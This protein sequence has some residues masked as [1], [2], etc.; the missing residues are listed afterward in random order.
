[1]KKWNFVPIS[2]IIFLIVVNSVS[3]SEASISSI[4]TTGEIDLPKGIKA[5]VSCDVKRSL[6]Y[7]DELESNQ[8]S[9]WD[10]GIGCKTF[11]IEIYV[12]SPIDEWYSRELEITSFGSYD[13]FTIVPGLSFSLDLKPSGY[14]YVS[15]AEIDNS[16]LIWDGVYQTKSFDAP[17]NFPEGG[18]F[19]TN[20]Q[21]TSFTL[22]PKTP[23]EGSETS[24]N[25]N[26]A[27]DFIL[28]LNI[29]MLSFT[30]TIT[31]YPIN[32]VLVFPPVSTNFRT[33]TTS[34][35]LLG[36]ILPSIGLIGM[37]LFLILLVAIIARRKKESIEK[38]TQK[39]KPDLDP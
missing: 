38:A 23:P 18:E 17:P 13:Y 37:L 31:N 35:N 29:E 7:P 25:V 34:D 11:K 12:P 4:V 5:I 14:V 39:K 28:S 6:N 2:L 19:F 30:E 27:L 16:E 32:S 21:T 15:N 26:F 9:I 33:Q 22:I 10:V 3:A 8:P 1:M 24:V 36:S 20:Y